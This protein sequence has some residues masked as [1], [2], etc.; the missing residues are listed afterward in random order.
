[1]VVHVSDSVRIKQI[2]RL[3]KEVTFRVVELI[4]RFTTPGIF[5]IGS[6]IA[7][8][9]RRLDENENWEY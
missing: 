5:V 3:D 1:M 8:K 4:E 2:V 9:K 7:Q 6:F